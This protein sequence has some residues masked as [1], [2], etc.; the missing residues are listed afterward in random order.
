LLLSDGFGTSRAM[1]RRRPDRAQ[2]LRTRQQWWRRHGAFV[3]GMGAGVVLVLVVVW[4][5]HGLRVV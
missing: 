2:T 3:R 1:S 5:L 4:L